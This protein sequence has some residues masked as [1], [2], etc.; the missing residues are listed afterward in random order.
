VNIFTQRKQVEA[1][2][3]SAIEDR[4]NSPPRLHCRLDQF[5][6]GFIKISESVALKML[7][8]RVQNERNDREMFLQEAQSEREKT[9][10]EVN[11]INL[12]T[13]KTL[14]TAEAEASLVRT[15]AI[16]EAQL[17]KAH[18]EINGTR[19]LLV[20]AGIESQEHKTVFTYIKT[21]RDRKQLDMVVSYLREHDNAVFTM[22]V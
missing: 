20:S 1:V 12:N 9:A 4:F 3:R 21:L 19:M 5:H 22:P 13:T 10:V 11:K 6:L 7:E 16:A 15:K 14:R 18:A 17:I 8:T 2:L